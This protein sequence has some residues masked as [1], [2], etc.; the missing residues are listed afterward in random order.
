MHRAL[1]ASS[2]HRKSASKSGRGSSPVTV[3]VHTAQQPERSSAIRA[4]RCGES[5]EGVLLRFMTV[6]FSG[7][8]TGGSVPADCV[9]CV[10][11]GAGVLRA[12]HLAAVGQAHPGDE[13]GAVAVQLDHAGAAH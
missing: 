5:F 6:V 1:R 12:A 7:R 2:P 4:P 9:S 13:S 10:C 11:S 8:R 3:R